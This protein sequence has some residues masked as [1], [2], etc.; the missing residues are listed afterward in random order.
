MLKV[1]ELF[2]GIGSYSAALAHIRRHWGIEFSIEDYVEIDKYAVRSYNAIHNTN[3]P[4]QDIK[5]WDKDM[6]IDLLLHGS[7][8]QDFSIAGLQMGGDEGTGTRSSLMYESIRIIHKL[9]PKFVVWENV[10]NILSKKHKHNFDNYIKTLNDFGYNSYYQILNARDYG[11]PQSRRRIF[12]VS[13]RKDMDNNNFAFP[14]KQPLTIQMKDLLE[15]IVDNKYYLSERM[16]DFIIDARGAQ[17]S[18]KWGKSI[19]QGKV[20]GVIAI[21]LC[22]CTANGSKRANCSNYICDNFN[23]EVSAKELK[24]MLASNAITLKDLKIRRLTPREC[25]R[26]MGFDDEYFDKAQSVN[27]NTQLYKQAG[28]SIVVNVAEAILINLLVKSQINY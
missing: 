9:N 5:D 4:T 11:I 13:I 20:N 19:K 23:R 2:G 28:N 16:K 7:P 18:T 10:P 24:E 15:P 3:F 6:D 17:K 14:M 12:T 21:A 8:C 22:A 27:S 1:L 25:W 26:L